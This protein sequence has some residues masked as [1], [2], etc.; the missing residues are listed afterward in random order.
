MMLETEHKFTHFCPTGELKDFDM[1]R[2]NL[3]I[4]HNVIMN[5]REA[6]KK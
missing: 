3:I 6:Q 1:I 5:L 4:A 2:W